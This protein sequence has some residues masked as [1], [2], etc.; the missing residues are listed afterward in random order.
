MR[1]TFYLVSLGCPKNLVDTEV[2]AA[3]LEGEGFAM[4]ADPREAAVII[5][6]TCAFI[7]PAKEESI[8]E[9]IRLGRH[10]DPRNGSCRCLVVTGCL[11]QRYGGVLE[12]ALPEVD[13]FLGVG[14]IEKIGLH[15]KK[16]MTTRGNAGKVFVDSPPFLMRARHP[17]HV[18]TPP[19]TAYLKIAEGCSN[20]CSYCVIPDIR[21]PFRSRD[22]NDI[23]REGERLVSLGVKELILIAQD[24]T[25]Y[26]EDLEERTRLEDLLIDLSALAGLRWLRLLYTYP[27]K[28]TKRLLEV[29]ADGEKICRYIDMPIQH[30]D[31]HI[32]KT[33]NRRGGREEIVRTIE[34]ARAVVEDVALRTSV[35]V[36][37]P[38]ETRKRFEKL[39]A[40]IEEA[41]FDHL[42][43]FAYSREEG[44]K[45]GEKRPRVSE[46][47]KDQR[48][49]L[50]MER[51]AAISFEIN[52]NLI[53]TTQEVLVEG[54]SDLK[55]YPYVGRLRRQAPD[56]DGVTYLRGEGLQPG[57]FTSCRI[58]AADTY[59][60]LAEATG[61]PGA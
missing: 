34:T 12:N 15:V 7:L 30:V 51:Q 57:L 29:M 19:W 49:R 6:N 60:L 4:T 22:R 52:R 16:S 37:L 47:E 20:R 3:I 31:D 45:A 56:I 46:R 27:T 55:G 17:R 8:D 33:M 21:G 5:V 40:F 23:L 53:G 14:E 2:M 48:R 25:A 13:L 18:L 36:G 9:I 24:V 54:K 11:P 35:I 58:V 26:G 38:G 28:V 10:K 61:T 39:L 43:V 50:I 59:D 44:S 41:R 42:G 1:N 32:L